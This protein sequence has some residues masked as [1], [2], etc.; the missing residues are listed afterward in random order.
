[1]AAIDLIA[2]GEGA[3]GA[4]E[5]ASV[6]RE[7]GSSMAEVSVATEIGPAGSSVADVIPWSCDGDEEA[8]RN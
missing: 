1:M 8:L 6:A 3:N 4:T 2:S 5:E 7:T